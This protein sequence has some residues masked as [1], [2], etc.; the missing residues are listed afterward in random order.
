MLHDQSFQKN[1]ILLKFRQ[2]YIFDNFFY[3]LERNLKHE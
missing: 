3:M 2:S 1:T